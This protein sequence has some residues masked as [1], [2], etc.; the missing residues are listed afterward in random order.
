M[1][2]CSHCI[3]APVTLASPRGGI[4]SICV[5]HGST[6]LFKYPPIEPPTLQDKRKSGADGSVRRSVCGPG[7]NAHSEQTNAD[8]EQTLNAI[9]F[10]P[11]ADRIVAV[12]RE[13]VILQM[14]S[15]D[16]RN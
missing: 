3:E 2:K 9:E 16:S 1:Q 6:N 12:F 8:R 13:I 11:V 10:S 14:A 4:V 15:G 5:K 7:S